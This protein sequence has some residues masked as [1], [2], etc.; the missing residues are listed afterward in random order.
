MKAQAAAL[1]LAVLLPALAR[2]QAPDGPQDFGTSDPS[3]TV[4]G[5]SDFTSE[6]GSSRATGE[7]LSWDTGGG[8]L[9]VPINMLPNGALLTQIVFYVR[10]QSPNADVWAEWCVNSFNSAT[11]QNNFIVCSFQ[12]E[13]TS[14][15]PGDTFLAMSPNVT[16]RYRFDIGGGTFVVNQYYLRVH[17]GAGDNSTAIRAARLLWKRQVSPAPQAAT[18]NDVPTSDP[19]FPF[20]EAL[21]ASGITVGCGGGSYCPDAP[22]TRRQMAVFLAKALGLHWPWN[23]P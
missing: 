10:D 22:L 15:V 11:G 3:I 7:G 1:M 14:G 18:F 17:T 23:A 5:F 20:V 12:P 21:A 16:I 6:S 19:A 4:I 8:S 2:A 13:A 9:T